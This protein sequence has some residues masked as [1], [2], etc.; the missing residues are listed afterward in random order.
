[1]GNA[2]QLGFVPKPV[3]NNQPVAIAEVFGPTL[4]GEGPSAGQPAVFLRTG[5]C[6][7]KCSWC[8]TPYTWDWTRYDK[9]EEVAR[10]T[11]SEVASEVLEL[12]RNKQRDFILVI[13]GGEPM[14]QSTAIYE[15][16]LDVGPW[17][18]HIEIETN[19]TLDPGDLTRLTNVYFNVSPK[20]RSSGNK[21]YVHDKYRYHARMRYKFVVTSLADLDEVAGYAFD[22]DLVWIMPEGT[23]TDTILQGLRDLAPAVIERRW[24]LTGRLHTLIWGNERGH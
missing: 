6:N 18:K 19:G 4:Q 10:K 22:P 9:N 11:V 16:L 12:V 14:M 7:L 17:F 2:N 5:F 24:N 20:L 3:I 13:T 15:L 21:S 8:D 23:D 1:M